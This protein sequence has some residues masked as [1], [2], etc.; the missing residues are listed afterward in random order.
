MFSEIFKG[1]LSFLSMSSD[2]VFFTKIEDH[3]YG[4]SNLGNVYEQLF[5]Q[6]CCRLLPE[7]E[8]VTDIFGRDNLIFEI[9]KKWS[10]LESRFD[11]NRTIV[12]YPKPF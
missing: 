9:L 7:Q 10:L 2:R 11:K 4:V 3:S 5:S 12:Y 6:K 8:S 1:K